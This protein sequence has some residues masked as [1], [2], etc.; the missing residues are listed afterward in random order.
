MVR[1]RVQILPLDQNHN[2][3]LN[4]M[5]QESIKNHNKP[6]KSTLVENNEQ[7]YIKSREKKICHPDRQ[8]LQ[9]DVF[10]ENLTYLF[11]LYSFFLCY[12]E[13]FYYYFHGLMVKYHIY[14][15]FASK[16]I[17]MS[18]GA[19]DLREYDF[20]PFLIFDR[21]SSMYFLEIS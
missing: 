6:S 13:A 4:F 7:L 3:E 15:M 16:Q 18:L 20:F 19:K 5:S 21:F 9:S 10:F 14:S 12:Y 8:S 11:V 1:V 17:N 2:K